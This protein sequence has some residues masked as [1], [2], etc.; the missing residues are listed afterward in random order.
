M[1]RDELSTEIQRIQEQRETALVTAQQPS[2]AISA[3]QWVLENTPEEQHESQN[4][5]RT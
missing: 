3:L 5:L 4:C 2:G 1:T